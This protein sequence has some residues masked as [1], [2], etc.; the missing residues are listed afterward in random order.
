VGALAQAGEEIRRLM[1]GGGRDVEARGTR[2]AL[3]RRQPGK[4]QAAWEGLS[5]RGCGCGSRWRVTG[6]RSG[7]ETRR[8]RCNG[9][10][11]GAWRGSEFWKSGRGQG[12]C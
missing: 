2:A 6:R 5:G 3:L 11:W 12:M 9:S 8:W 4:R 1:R 10:G 7:R